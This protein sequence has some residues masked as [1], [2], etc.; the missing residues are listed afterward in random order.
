MIFKWLLGVL[1]VLNHI[2]CLR[3]Q[4]YSSM[5]RIMK[6]PSP[7]GLVFL[8]GCP[9]SGTYL[10]SLMM[11]T[12]LSV[13]VPVETHFIPLFYRYLPLWGDLGVYRNRAR[14][15]NDIYEFLEIWTPRS[16]RNRNLKI[17]RKYCLLATRGREEA[18]LRRSGSYPDLVANLYTVFAGIHGARAKGDKSA[19]FRHGPFD[20]LD[21][22]ARNM[23]VIHMI[24]D[25]RDVALSWLG[26]WSGPRDIAQA[27]WTWAA[28]VRKKRDWGRCHPDRYLEIRYEDLLEC[29]EE[30]IKQAADFLGLPVR[31]HIAFHQTELAETLAAGAPHHLINRPLDPGN[32]E[33]WRTRM[34]PADQYIFQYLAGRELVDFGYPPAAV[35]KGPGLKMNLARHLAVSVFHRFFSRREFRLSLKGLLP[36]ALFVCNRAGIPLARILNRNIHDW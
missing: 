22:C 33:K 1:S 36:L 24:R 2:R 3:Q 12:R 13:A 14:L 4:G 30:T 11:S 28:H 23:K 7:N 17:I 21:R 26:L 16:E 8:V 31:N 34:S 9:R 27:A 19:F 32:K 35:P 15:L 29:P 10:F 25:G 5:I 18:I 20:R 6:Q